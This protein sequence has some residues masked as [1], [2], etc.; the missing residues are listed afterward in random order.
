MFFPLITSATSQQ[1]R[2]LIDVNKSNY[3]ASNKIELSIVNKSP[4]NI[5]LSS[6]FL[7]LYS[8]TFTLLSKPEGI[9]IDPVQEIIADPQLVRGFYV[10]ENYILIPKGE[11]T[12]HVLD[13]SNIYSAN[14]RY[15]YNIFIEHFPCSALG[16]SKMNSED[17][18]I[19]LV[20]GFVI[21]NP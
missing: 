9:I 17:R 12:Y 7:H 13:L 19:K 18:K 2:Q 20:T 6:R 14:G 3:A 21:L 4:Y 10:G 15:Y 8:D 5:C 16:K 1:N 11:T